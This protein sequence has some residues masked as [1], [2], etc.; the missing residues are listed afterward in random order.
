M[1][2][3]NHS[4]PGL[5]EA[6]A[7]RS[8]RRPKKAAGTKRTPAMQQYDRFKREH[9][10]CVLFFRM[11]DF[12]ELFDEDAV[13]A[14]RALGITLTKRNGGTPM[15]GVPHHALEGYLR[16][17]IDGGFRVAVADQVQ[18][19]KDAKG[20]V[21][22]AVTRV[23]T[24]GT[25]V[26]EGLLDEGRPNLVAAVVLG[27]ADD[28]AAADALTATIAAAEVSTGAFT[29]VTV[30]ADR[31]AD[32]LAR[33]GPSEVVHAA[34]DDADGP[35]PALERA[36]A[37]HSFALSPRPAWTF[38]ADEAERTLRE[39]YRVA[40]L[41]G[42]GLAGDP[43][44]VAAAGALLRYLLDTQSPDAARLAPGSTSPAAPAVRAAAA[45]A[46]TRPLA[47][48][49]P[50]RRV[51]P[52]AGLVLDRAS[53]ASLEIE[54]TMRSGSAD[55][56]LLATIHRCVTPMGK[57]LLR[58]W[59]CYP[60]ADRAAIEARQ[61]VVA[62]LLADDRLRGELLELIR[63]VQDV[64]R[65][66]GRVAMRRATP[67][68]LVALGV[69]VGQLAALRETLGRTPA[70]AAVRERLD[71]LAAALEPLAADIAAR[72]LP[73]PPPHLREGGLFRDGVDAELD[74]ARS[75]QRDASAWL[76]EYQARLLEETGIGSLKVGFNKVF[77][78]YIEVTAAHRDRVPA[79][80]HRKQTLKNAER[81]ITDELKTFE[82]KVMSAE[83]RAIEREQLLFAE[84][85][86]DAAMAASELADYAGL[87]AE[88]DV[89]L[90]FAEHAARRGWVRP[91]LVD[92]PVV[93]IVGGRHPVLEDRLGEG[94]V[95]NDCTL[96]RGGDEEAGVPPRL[97]L[98]TGP[99]MAGKSTYIRQ[100]ALLTLLAHVGSWVPA[101]RAVIGLTD[102]IFTRIGASDELHEGQSTFMVE[103][104]E[105]AAI[106]HHATE[107]SLVVLDEIGRGTSTLDGLALAWAIAETMHGRGS[108]TLFATHYHELTDLAE[109]LPGVTNLHVAV[110]EWEGDVIFLHR[111]AP[112][113]AAGSYGIHVARIAGLP[114]ETVARAGEVLRSLAVQA[115]VPLAGDGTTAAGGGSGQLGLFGGAGDDPG[116][117]P[118]SAT[119]V[120]GAAAAAES[121]SARGTAEEPLSGTGDPA[122]APAPEHPVIETVR[123]LSLE[124]MTPLEAFDVLRELRARTK[125]EP[126]ATSPEAPSRQGPS[127]EAPPREAPPREAPSQEAPPREA[128]PREA[129]PREAAP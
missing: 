113:R 68:D 80:F 81:F 8:K 43:P 89:L 23:L 119:R 34:D 44:A 71:G 94:F 129:P 22:R 72:C 105:T 21:E 35:P 41:D 54:R 106:L 24:P 108:R 67:R 30:P 79:G 121:P 107:R 84:L 110:R 78:Y 96:G 60:L 55:G 52:A 18:D 64:A 73:E 4:A 87:V 128:P 15:A 102:R 53:L 97:A 61:T 123:G 58:E 126:P 69:S 7:E 47:H 51:D 88:L 114:R 3:A 91:E 16:R 20:V 33:R 99:N 6:A 17:M 45:A 2:R 122:A 12:Y 83:S 27:G 38:R 9:P 13:T 92:E 70:L 118:P 124:R 10:G 93:E 77:G 36:R 65:I 109:H 104:V 115:H 74:E 32:E 42:F 85:C 46:G 59:L 111:I 66:A 50:P 101:E 63:P 48:L 14:H 86:A 19:P 127:Q 26:D 49:D 116:T 39:H 112:G 90:G 56:S 5:A 75:L 31:L 28:P 103:M 25:L 117:A 125:P 95:P 62:A 11:G 40:T 76:A 100:V 37:V 120:A 98:I 1:P 57:R 29:I 82:D